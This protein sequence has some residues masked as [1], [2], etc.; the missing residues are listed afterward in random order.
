MYFTVHVL[1]FFNFHVLLFI[2]YG[3]MFLSHNI[4][5]L[6]ISLSCC[7]D[8]IFHWEIWLWVIVVSCCLN[9]CLYVY[10]V[11]LYVII[12]NGIRFQCLFNEYF[13][14][15]VTSEYLKDC[16]DLFRFRVM[17]LIV[18]FISMSAW[19]LGHLRAWQLFKLRGNVFHGQI[20]FQNILVAH[21]MVTV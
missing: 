19:P 14:F 1:I 2:C 16:L 13:E 4:V 15:H 18:M 3:L 7:L 20:L 12:E 8:F 10:S 17:R 11:L 21:W 9:C 6:C 5:C